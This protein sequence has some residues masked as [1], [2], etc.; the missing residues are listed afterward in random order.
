MINFIDVGKRKSIIILNLFKQYLD[1]T[2]QSQFSY[3]DDTT[4]PY[5]FLSRKE[6]S[7]NSVSDLSRYL[8]DSFLP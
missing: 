6:K 4:K 1:N 3:Q 8:K 5:F 2:V 7:E